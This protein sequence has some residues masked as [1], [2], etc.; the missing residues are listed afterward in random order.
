MATQTKKTNARATEQHNVTV[1]A[2]LDAA[3]DALSR[4]ISKP[5]AES[6][7]KQTVAL[8]ATVG[9]GVA[10]GAWIFG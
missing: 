4:D 6:R 1:G 3:L 8:G 5:A 9:V 10:L 2:R 7:T